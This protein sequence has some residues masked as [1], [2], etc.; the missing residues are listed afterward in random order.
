TSGFASNGGLGV[1]FLPSLPTVRITSVDGRAVPAISTGSIGGTDV[2][3]DGPGTVTIALEAS[4]VPPGT[5]I[6]VT[7]KPEAD[8]AVIGP[9]PSDGLSGTFDNSTTSVDVTFP[10]AGLFF[11]EARATFTL[12]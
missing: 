11:I 10:S 3:I 9:V 7:A 8:G 4:R 6:D 5:T 2:I 1:V 12:P